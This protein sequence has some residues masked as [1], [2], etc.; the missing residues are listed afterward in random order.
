MLMP[1]SVFAE[2]VLATLPANPAFLEYLDQ[3]NSG[4]VTTDSLAET[5]LI[6]EPLLRGQSSQEVTEELPEAYDLRATGRISPI[7]NQGSYGTC[8]TFATMESLES[9]L[10]PEANMDFSENNLAWNHGYDWNFDDAGN[11]YMATAYLSRYSGPVSEIDDPYASEQTT[12]L[13]A[14]YHIQSVEMLP[15]N[16][17]VIKQAI[18]DG[19]A[20]ATAIHVAAEFIAVENNA[21][22]Y[23]GTEEPNHA[24]TIVGWDDNYDKN[25]FAS[26]PEGDGAWIIQNSWG[27]EA[28]EDGF[29]YLSYY[30]TWAGN[31]VTAFHNAESLDNYGRVYQYD[32][33]GT[34]ST[35][36][37]YH[38]DTPSAWGANIFTPVAS[39]NLAAISTYITSF[40]TDV[41]ISI[42]SNLTDENNPVSGELVSN[43]T[44]YFDNMGYYTVKLDTPVALNAFEPFSVVVKYSTN[45][46]I[47]AIPVE[48]KLNGYSSAAWANS[49]QSFISDDG[50]ELYE[51]ENVWTD[52]SLNGSNVCIKAFTEYTE[53][54]A[55]AVDVFYRSYVE[56]SG[57][58]EVMT[59]GQTAGSEG[60]GLRLEAFEVKLDPKN[61]DLGLSARTHV[62]NIGWQDWCTDGSLSGTT[63]QGLRLEAVELKLSGSSADLFDIYY[64]VH[65]Q[66]IGWMGWAKNGQSAG[67]EGFGYRLEAIE[68]QVIPKGQ[69][70]DSGTTAPFVGTSESL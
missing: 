5:G 7:Y 43:Q 41:E 1:Q 9:Y 68:I 34:T 10:M 35:M 23:L 16:P 52:V 62:E 31:D 18:I 19:G 32:Y 60:Y 28:G 51:D 66:N 14:L 47:T 30:D 61:Y 63:D 50:G 39:E 15:N 69:A 11:Y 21:L 4:S 55:D 70:F 2:S 8:W 17:D 65:A 49:G 29:Y 64:R 58:D 26:S 40:D 24:V 57:W 48:T 46:K 56:N 6:P 33:L 36:G 42:Y 12:G 3:V 13:D 37:Y 53:S 20:V 27:V 67:T 38:P 45:D 59:D 25:L 22:Y 54:T 44:A